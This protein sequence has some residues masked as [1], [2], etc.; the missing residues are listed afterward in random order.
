MKFGKPIWG[1][2]MQI[3]S[4]LGYSLKMRESE[5]IQIHARL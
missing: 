3:T 2:F 5:E 1:E 4:A